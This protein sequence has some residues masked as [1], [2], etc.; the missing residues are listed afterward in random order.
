MQRNGQRLLILKRRNALTKVLAIFAA[1]FMRGK[2]RI[3][4]ATVAFGLGINKADVVGVI[5]LYLPS[6]PENYLQETGR[7]GRDGQPAK[8][9]ALVLADEVVIKHSLAHSN[10]LS[11]SQIKVLL[12]ILRNQVLAILNIISSD[13][14]HEIDGTTFGASLNVALPIEST[15]MTTDCKIET[16]ETLLS[17]LEEADCENPLV[18]I[19]GTLTDQATITLKRR[20][21]EKLSKV[22]RIAECIIKCGTCLDSPEATKNQGE[23]DPQTKEQRFLAYSFG[24]H[25]FSITRCASLLG[26]SAEPRHVFATLRR[27]QNSGELELNLDASPMGRAL[28]MKVEPSG[29]QLLT[30]SDTFVDEMTHELTQRF[31]ANV[32]AAAKKA[33]DAKHILHRVASVDQSESSKGSM[34]ASLALFRELVEKYFDGHEVKETSSDDEEIPRGAR[35]SMKNE[36]R[37]D[38]SSL[39][40][41]I[42]SFPNFQQSSRVVGLDILCPENSDYTALA[43]TKFMHGIDTPRAPYAAFSS[44]PLYGKW[45]DVEFSSLLSEVTALLDLSE[46]T[47]GGR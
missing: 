21:L 38:V 30:R 36:L 19:Q 8:A 13:I 46:A 33:L 22:E 25:S 14:G 6:S 3:C 35:A 15:V 27:L 17:L 39:L 34:S 2:A 1:K 37:V 23:D 9:I 47:S 29:V 26:E 45:R 32:A 5:H 10:M 4:V 43:M 40:R 42:K 18:K 20:S 7:A 24:S 41:D 12:Q 16:V 31:S 44:H 11:T 28:H